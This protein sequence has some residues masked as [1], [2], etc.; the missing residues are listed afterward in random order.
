M[1]QLQ[2]AIEDRENVMLQLQA[3][4]GQGELTEHK[5]Q[6]IEAQ[7][8]DL[9][10]Q[11]AGLKSSKLVEIPAIRHALTLY[12]NITNLRWNYDAP[13]DVVRGFIALDDDVRHFDIAEKDSVRVADQLWGMM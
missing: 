2:Q 10:E 3:M 8:R 7:K 13:L 5:M 4:E 12:A 6:E 9:V 1:R 11:L